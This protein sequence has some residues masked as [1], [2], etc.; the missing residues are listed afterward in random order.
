MGTD[1]GPSA[2]ATG[3]VGGPAPGVTEAF[4]AMCAMPTGPSR[5][6]ERAAGGV[7]RLP[8][9]AQAVSESL[10]SQDATVRERGWLLV[11]AR[12][13]QE[14]ESDRDWTQ[15]AAHWLDLGRADWSESARLCADVA[16]RARSAHRS[17]LVFLSTDQVAATAVD[18][19]RGRAL[20]HLF[21]TTLRYDFRCSA[22]SRFFARVPASVASAVD[23]YI[24]A[25]R[26]FALLGRSDK[27]GLPLMEEVLRR[28]GD[29]G[30]VLHTLLHGLWLGERLDDQARLMLDLLAAPVFAD[31]TD[32]EAAFRKAGALRMA[33]DHAGAL[34]A[35]EAAIEHLEPTEVVVHADCV[36]ERALILADRDLRAVVDG[37]RDLLVR[38]GLQP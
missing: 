23:P 30:K 7:W 26:A 4:A 37:A 36:R 38:S 35:I 6:V 3:V 13:V 1:E 28:A 5:V 22:I 31:G 24:A 32:P 10:A 15:E 9:A 20:W 11:Y 14:M 33:G 27:A 34:E 8:G 2:G 16:W 21:L 18:T 12:I 19:A 29:D 17:A 25:L